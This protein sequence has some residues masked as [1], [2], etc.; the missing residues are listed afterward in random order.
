[1]IKSFRGWELDNFYFHSSKAR[2]ID[3]SI[4]DALRRKLDIIHSAEAEID[5]KV[6]PGKRFEHLSGKLNDR[7]S[8]RVNRKYRLIFKWD[9]GEAIDLYLV[10]YEYK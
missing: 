8:I 7:C 10:P 9:N 2:G 1:M 3:K 4:E 5:L 6:P